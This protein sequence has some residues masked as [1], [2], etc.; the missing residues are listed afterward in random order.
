MEKAA[1][2]ALLLLAFSGALAGGQLSL[3]HLSFGEVCPMLGPIPAC[4]VV[5]LGYLSISV[6]A[7]LGATSRA[8]WLFF[9]GWVPVA[10]LAFSGVVLELLGND[11]C[12]PG[13]L[14]IPQCVYSFAMAM[15]CL[16]LFLLYRRFAALPKLSG[17]I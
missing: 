13:A 14:G 5:F 15:M 1:R 4:L 16:G 3:Q 12:P 9:L 11:I 2:Y 17:E 8:K 7:A 6:S 10:G